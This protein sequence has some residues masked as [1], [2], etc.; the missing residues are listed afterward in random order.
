MISIA[1]P[2]FAAQAIRKIHDLGWHLLHLIAYSGSGFNVLKMAGLEK[3]KGLISTYFAKT[4]TDLVM[5][6]DEDVK[7]Y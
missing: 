6:D 3:S 7:Q 5:R 1:T 4:V 2:K